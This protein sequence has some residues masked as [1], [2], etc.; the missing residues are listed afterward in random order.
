MTTRVISLWR[1]HPC[2]QSVFLLIE[3]ILALKAIECHFKI[4][5]KK[6]LTLVVI[7]YDIYE[8]SLRRVSQISYEMTT[9]VM[10]SSTH[11]PVTLQKVKLESAY[12]IYLSVHIRLNISKSF[13]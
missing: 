3:I 11:T 10:S 2:Q 13:L 1:V 12:L 8:T 6:N 9:R 7:S 5:D 4:L